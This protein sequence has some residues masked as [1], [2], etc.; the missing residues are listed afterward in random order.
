M[1][2]ESPPP[3]HD[4]LSEFHYEGSDLEDLSNIPNYNDWIFDGFRSF[5]GGD[6]VE[7][8]AGIGTMSRLI[9]SNAARLQ[10]VEPSPNLAPRLAEVFADDDGVTVHQQMLEGFIADRKRIGRVIYDDFGRAADANLVHL[11]SNQCRM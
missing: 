3:A 8:G 4:G 2:E 1:N 9:R 7:F 11:P 10:L 6:V 5:V